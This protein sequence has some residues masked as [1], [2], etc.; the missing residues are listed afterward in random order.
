MLDIYKTTHF[1][2]KLLHLASSAQN[3]DLVELFLFRLNNIL[4]KF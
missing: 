1:T 2:A 4:N 3:S